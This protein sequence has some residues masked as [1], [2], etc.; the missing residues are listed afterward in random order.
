V[1]PTGKTKWGKRNKKVK[2]KEEKD[3]DEGKKKPKFVKVVK[4]PVG[5]HFFVR[6]SSMA[7]HYS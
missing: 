3:E 2:G 7:P 1:E 6:N 5:S 4:C